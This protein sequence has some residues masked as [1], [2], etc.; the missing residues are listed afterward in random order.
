MQES[1]V[2]HSMAFKQL[3]IEPQ[4]AKGQLVSTFEQVNFLGGR[5]SSG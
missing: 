5:A 1:P 3:A 4:M 2:Q